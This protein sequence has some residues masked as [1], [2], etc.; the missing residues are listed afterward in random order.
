[1]VALPCWWGITVRFFLA[2]SLY[3]RPRGPMRHSPSRGL[4]TSSS[5]ARM[6]PCTP[7]MPH[8]AFFIGGGHA[9]SDRLRSRQRWNAEDWL[10]WVSLPAG[11]GIASSSWSTRA[12]AS[13]TARRP[14]RRSRTP[15]WPDTTGWAVRRDVDRKR[16]SPT[17]ARSGGGAAAQL[18]AQRRSVAALILEVVLHERASLRRP[19]LRAR[20]SRVDPFDTMAV[21]AH[22]GPCWCPWHTRRDRPGRARSRPRCS[23][24]WGEVHPVAL[25]AQRLLPPVDRRRGLL[26]PSRILVDRRAAP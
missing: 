18:A 4:G 20:L 2:R 26:V 10:G 6:E 13:R 25:R 14:R 8:R 22:R 5:P 12:T 7:G 17:A 24:A 11:R 21:L 16:T 1:M 23:S 15:S 9:P 3:P 19:I